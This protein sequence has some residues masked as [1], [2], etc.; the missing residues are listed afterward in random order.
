MVIDKRNFL[1]QSCYANVHVTRG[2]VINPELSKKFSEISAQ[3][4]IHCP[5]IN[6]LFSLRVYSVLRLID[7]CS[8]CDSLIRITNV[9]CTIS[10]VRLIYKL[11][12]LK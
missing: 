2:H 3:T 6:R 5:M 9:N 7:A 8:I 12:R 11:I 1:F 10:V 4:L